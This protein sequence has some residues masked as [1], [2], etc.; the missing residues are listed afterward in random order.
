MPLERFYKLPEERQAKILAAAR[1]E[2]AEHGG[3]ASYNRIIAAAG[4]SKGA[5]YYYFADRDDL[6][7]EVL[8][9]VF[10]ELVSAVGR[11]APVADAATFWAVF[12]DVT[13]RA[14]AALMESAE[15]R[16]L[17]KALYAPST[18]A[19]AHQ[20]VQTRFHTLVESALALGQQVDA[21]REDVPLG[22]LTATFTAAA[23]GIDRWYAEH[24]EELSPDALQEAEGASLK[25]CRALLSP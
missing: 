9:Q 4:I 18:G 15:L 10:D 7:G 1:A 23:F 8:D 11:V 24:L 22:L 20:R 5:M 3:D 16:A 19:S 6:F 14:S 21:V 2:F 17:G 25:L 13:R 12:E